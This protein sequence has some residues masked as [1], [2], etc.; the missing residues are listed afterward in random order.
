MSE[1]PMGSAASRVKVN[2]CH[3]LRKHLLGFKL[4]EGLQ[5]FVCDNIFTTFYP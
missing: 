5:S 2:L 1:P 3:D 4:T